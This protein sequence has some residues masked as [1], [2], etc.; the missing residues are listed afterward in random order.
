M[1]PLT[2]DQIRA[3]FVNGTQGEG[4]RL[5]I[6]SLADVAWEDLDFFGW[7]DPAAPRNGGMAL[8]RGDEPIAIML[9]ATDRAASIRQGMCS[10]C[11]TFHSSSDVALMSAKRAGSRGRDHNVVGAAMCADLA[12]SL[13]ARKRKQPKRVQP[14]ESL[15]IEA[16]VARLQ[17][18][19]DRF[20]ARVVD[21]L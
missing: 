12:C 16:R 7:R 4:K 1:Q 3:S 17:G 10:L 5:T 19:L 18:N 8:W 21:G 13:Y 2:S 14:Q 9:R 6:P 11:H 15:G 20:V